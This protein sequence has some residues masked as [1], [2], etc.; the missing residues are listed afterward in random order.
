[1]SR[2]RERERERGTCISLWPKWTRTRPCCTAPEQ[3]QNSC[4][5]FFNSP[6]RFI[7]GKNNYYNF[8]FTL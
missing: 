3:R 8:I 6:F 2:E 1:M 4:C 7:E 5:F